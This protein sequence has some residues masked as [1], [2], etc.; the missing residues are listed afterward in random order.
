MVTKTKASGGNNKQ[1]K[2]DLLERNGKRKIKPKITLLAF[3]LAF[4][5]IIWCS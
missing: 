4:F 2:Y 5:D 3:G 1:A